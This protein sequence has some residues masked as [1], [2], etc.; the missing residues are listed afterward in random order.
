M[1]RIKKERD[2]QMIKLV[3]KKTKGTQ[4]KKPRWHMGITE[5][6][7]GQEMKLLEIEEEEESDG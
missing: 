2:T 5:F 1:L 7:D 6:R 4:K 3:I